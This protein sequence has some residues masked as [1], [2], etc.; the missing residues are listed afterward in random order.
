MSLKLASGSYDGTIRFWDPSTGNCIKKETI[1][2]NQP[3]KGVPNKIEISENKKNLLV[4]MNSSI[5]I[6]DL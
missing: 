5:K 1:D 4:G 3:F 6:F 2:L